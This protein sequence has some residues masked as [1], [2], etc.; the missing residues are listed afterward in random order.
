MYEVALEMSGVRHDIRV[1]N[2]NMTCLNRAH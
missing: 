2:E 1:L